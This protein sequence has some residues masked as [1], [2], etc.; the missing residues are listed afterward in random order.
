M[1]QI[2]RE[3]VVAAALDLL[4]E[5]GLDQVSTRVLAQ[6]LGIKQPS[7]YW[8]FHNKDELLAAMAAAAMAPHARF[9]LPNRS[10]DWRQ[11][12]M[13]N[14]LSF[15]QT[16]LLRRD[17]ARLH[18]GSRPVGEGL[19][20]T[21]AKVDFLVGCGLSRRLVEMAMLAASRFTVGSVLEQQAEQTT[22]PTSQRP[23]SEIDHDEAFRAGIGLIVA[24]L[25][26]ENDH[27]K[28]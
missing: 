14:Y 8:H 28:R 26:Q 12:F 19:E 27:I 24:G 17:G 7:L 3:L 6:R 18:A 10:D 13:D 2:T 21:T 5:V 22:P 11:W 20:R 15:R 16:L 25:A 1:S 9:G 4:D 23:G